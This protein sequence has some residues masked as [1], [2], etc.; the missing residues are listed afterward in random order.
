MLKL[1]LDYRESCL[2]DILKNKPELKNIVEVKNLDIG[3]IIITNKS[4]KLIIER[5]TINDLVSSVKDGR[6]REQ[7]MRLLSYQ[8]KNINTR[9][10]YLVEGYELSTY[11]KNEQGALHGSLISMSLRDNI[12]IFRTKDVAS[13][14]LLILRLYSRL[15]KNPSELFLKVSKPE[16][17]IKSITIGIKSDTDESVVVHRLEDNVNDNVKQIEIASKKTDITNNLSKCYLDNIKIK[18]K[19][20]ITSDNWFSLALANIPGVSV[21]IAKSITSKYNK[22]QDLINAYNKLDEEKDREKLLCEL[23]IIDANR[24]IGKVIS[25]KIYDFLIK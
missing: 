10:I 13:S 9:I 3:D 15:L 4:H 7:K 2:I 24:K 23:K 8:K 16:P 22:I 17:E 5:K 11:L 6:Y 19:D 20:N 1:E 18:K 12:P 25:K 21:K 14:I